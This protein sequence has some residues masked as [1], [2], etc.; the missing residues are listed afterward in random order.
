MNP[1]PSGSAAK[2]E[3]KRTSVQDLMDH[4]YIV[5]ARKARKNNAPLRADG[6]NRSLSMIP[7]FLSEL[8]LPAEY[9]S[10]VSSP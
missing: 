2:Y 8:N 7:S 10:L 4:A 6:W 5:L 3:K 1:Q 9:D